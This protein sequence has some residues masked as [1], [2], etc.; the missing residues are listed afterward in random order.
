MTRDKELY[1]ITAF[2]DRL[3]LPTAEYL[4]KYPDGAKLLDDVQDALT[5]LEEHVG[6]KGGLNVL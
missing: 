4:H 2:W 3:T 5:E 1:I 6:N